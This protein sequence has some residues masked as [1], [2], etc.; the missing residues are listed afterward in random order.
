LGD[1]R[2]LLVVSASDILIAVSGRYGML[3]EI[4]LVLKA[5]KPVIGID[6]W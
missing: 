3:S 2:N 1:G 6:T 4:G 5:G